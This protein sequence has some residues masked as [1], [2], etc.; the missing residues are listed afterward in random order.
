MGAGSGSAC[1]AGCAF[2][3]H[4][5]EK[6]SLSVWAKMGAPFS[7]LLV[8]VCGP[9]RGKYRLLPQ[10]VSDCISSASTHRVFI[11]SKIIFVRARLALC[12][13]HFSCLF[14]D[15]KLHQDERPALL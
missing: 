2:W 3:I 9:L 6:D 10:V 1:Y 11:F 14:S 13:R 7:C 4:L 5:V 15:L 8:V 12:T